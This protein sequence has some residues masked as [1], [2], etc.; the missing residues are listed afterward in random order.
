MVVF[1][2]K[3]NSSCPHEQHFSPNHL[4]WGC[5]TAGKCLLVLIACSNNPPNAKYS[6][7]N[8]C[9]QETS[10]NSTYF[11]NSMSEQA[12]L[13]TKSRRFFFIAWDKQRCLNGLQNLKPNSRH[14]LRSTILVLSTG[15]ASTNLTS[16]WLEEVFGGWATTLRVRCC[17]LVLE[18]LCRPHLFLS[19]KTHAFW[20]FMIA[21]CPAFC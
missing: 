9:T 4:A 8:C 3:T 14:N 13:F 10:E 2:R 17:S 11:H 6:N 15:P 21:W 7:R 12:S 19:S 16:K 18:N 5:F 20:H 1:G